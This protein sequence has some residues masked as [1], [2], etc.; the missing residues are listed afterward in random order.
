MSVDVYDEN[1]E[2][3]D[4]KVTE[5]DVPT[6]YEKHEEGTTVTNTFKAPIDEKYDITLT[7]VWDDNCNEAEKRP[8][9]I[10]FDLYKINVEGEKVVVEENIELKG[11]PKAEQWT[12]TRN[13]Q[14][15][16]EKAN[17]IK[18]FVVEKETGSIFYINVD[19]DKTD[20]TVTNKFEVP[21]DKADISVKKYGTIIITQQKE[22]Q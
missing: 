19:T 17:V 10:K 15:Y 11:D 2:E 22:N 6:W 14:K 16:D 20:L 3:I 1:G 5:K 9:S 18:Y 7:K 12:I 13:V 21:N 8:T 4:Y